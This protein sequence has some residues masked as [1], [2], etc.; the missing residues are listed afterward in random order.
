MS[1]NMA[2]KVRGKV[3]GPK[4][5]TV[6]N[7]RKYVVLAL[8]L[9][10]SSA[11]VA[12]TSAPAEAPKLTLDPVF[13]N[14]QKREEPLQN[15]PASITALGEKTIQDADITSIRDASFYVPNLTLQEFSN[16]RL[17][18]PFIRGIGSGRNSPAVTTYID[19]VPQLSFA[20]SNIELVDISRIEVLRGPQTTLYGRNTLG[21]VINIF[22]SK[23]DTENFAA[24]GRAD[25]G[26]YMLQDYRGYVNVPIE[27]GL[28]AIRVAGGFTSR[29]GYTK[30]LYTGN[31]LDSR[32]AEF[33][34]FALTLTPNERL[35]ITWRFNGE[36][37]RDGDYAL[38]DLASVRANPHRAFRDYEGYSDRDIAGTSLEVNYRLDWAT[39]T[40]VSAYKGF[41]SRDVTD[42][43]AS[44]ADLIRRTNRE[45]QTDFTQEFRLASPT[46]A[47]IVLN[48]NAKLSWLVGVFVFDTDYQQRAANEYRPDAVGF[49]IVP[50]PFTGFENGDLRDTGIGVFGQATLTLFENLDLTAGLRYDYEDK[51][52]ELRSFADSIF[53]PGSSVDAGADFSQVT[54]RFAAAYRWSKD[55]MTYASVAQGY[56]SGG[57]NASAPSGSTTYEPESAW[58]YEVGA[59]T[60]WFD[61]KLSL[62]A[63]AYY[64]N[65]TDLQLDVPTGAPGVFYIDNVGSAWSTGAEVELVAR[66]TDWLDVF[67]GIGINRAKFA[68]YIQPSG[69]S[70]AGNRLPFAPDITA[71]LGVQITQRFDRNMYGYVRPEVL[72]VGQYA[73][74]ASSAASQAAYS[75]TNIRIGLGSTN[76]NGAHVRLE[77]W[78]RNVFDQNYVPLA[79][80]FQLAPSGYVGESGAPRTFGVSL[81]VDF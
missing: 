64:I 77:G 31:D 51:G 79:F 28:A 40:S 24:G 7:M 1:I 32:E 48:E 27:K 69:A 14:A 35:E 22:S 45:K 17:S 41:E 60:D 37:A 80:P 5:A 33:G 75:I 49:G 8:T 70:A 62:N 6:K 71:N 12:Q 36:R 73:Y 19:N 52:A 34:K 13:V 10:A 56:K 63:T 50:F 44:P 68:E 11:A 15:V 2:A 18:F 55:I 72:L 3:Y 43:D 67:A 46:E 81:S 66:P 76:F 38:Y 74:D 61:R 54:P 23:A 20:T 25:I 9:A 39:F 65:W 78:C 16:R 42:L 26:N 47:P 29:D 30:N 4:M 53:I 57:F 21:G 59:K 58:T